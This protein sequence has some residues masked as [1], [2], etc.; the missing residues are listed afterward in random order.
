MKLSW[1]ELKLYN[2]EYWQP[3]GRGEIKQAK[4]VGIVLC[5]FVLFSK[6][7]IMMTG[8]CGTLAKAKTTIN[9]ALKKFT[10]YPLR[11]SP[12]YCFLF[13]HISFLLSMWYLIPPASLNALPQHALLY[14]SS[15]PGTYML[16]VLRLSPTSLISSHY[17]LSPASQYY[18]CLLVQLP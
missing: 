16:L 7:H 2:S 12:W 5:N 9:T 13:L 17:N 14:N 6:E 4:K 1:E 18:L 15:K 8:P 10:L 11:S 3:K